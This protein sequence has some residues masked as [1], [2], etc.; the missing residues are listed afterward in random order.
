[1][2]CVDHKTFMMLP[3]GTFYAKGAQWAFD[4]LQ[5]KQENVGEYDWYAQ[6][7]NSVDGNDGG[8]VIDRLEEMLA[9]G[10][11]YPMDWS[12]CR[13][14][15]YKF[16]EKYVFLIFERDDLLKIRECIDVAL[17]LPIDI[18]GSVERKAIR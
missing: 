9:K 8:E 17:A 15:E 5:V 11:S 14:G 4:E 18:D 2:R 12:V 1:M 16:D 10:A 13:E 7:F 3:V 6:S